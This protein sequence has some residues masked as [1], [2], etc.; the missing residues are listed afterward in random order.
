MYQVYRPPHRPPYTYNT[1][2]L[3][4]FLLLSVFSMLLYI[5]IYSTLC[6]GHLSLI[7]LT[8]WVCLFGAQVEYRDS[9]RRQGARYRYYQGYD[10]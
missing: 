5:Y 6:I 10:S 4:L 7:V 9:M 2:T 8:P 3:Y 1:P